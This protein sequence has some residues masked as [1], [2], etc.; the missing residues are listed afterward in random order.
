MYPAMWPNPVSDRQYTQRVR[1]HKPSSLLPKV[2]DAACGYLTPEQWAN[3]PYRIYTPWALADIARV[4][5]AYGT[6]FNRTD[7][8]DQDLKA[9]L[10]AYD[11]LD[12]PFRREKDL[13]SF[14]LRKAGEQLT[15]QSSGLTAMARTVALFAQNRDT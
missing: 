12:D 6:E 14:L 4:A 13:R 7:A 15:W 10:G 5:L 1:K 2:A 8:S 3:S 9:I 11:Q